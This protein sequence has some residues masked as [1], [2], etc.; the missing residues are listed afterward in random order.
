[1]GFLHKLWDETLAGPPP[2]TGLAKLRKY[3]SFSGTTTSSTVAS[4][5]PPRQVVV[6]PDH[7]D[8]V[9]RTITILRRTNSTPLRTFSTD[10]PAG[11]TSCSDP[12]SPNSR[13]TTPRTPSTRK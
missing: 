7:H 4:K 3:D 8:G 5:T 9:T 6:P 13:C 2:E 11:S 1:M 10:L 12:D